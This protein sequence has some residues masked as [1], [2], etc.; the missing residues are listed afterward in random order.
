MET[1]W[2]LKTATDQGTLVKS[3]SLLRFQNVATGKFFTIDP[4]ESEWKI[5]K[6]GDDRDGY[7]RHQETIQFE[8]AEGGV[9]FVEQV[10]RDEQISCND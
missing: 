9:V 5:I 7:V 10:E 4:A 8:T 6:V 3:Q 1:W 2:E